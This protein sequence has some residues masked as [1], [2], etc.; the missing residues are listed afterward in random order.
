LGGSFGGVLTHLFA[1]AS[2]LSDF[3]VISKQYA[4]KK[5]L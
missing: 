4:R 3:I 5:S 2:L 1:A